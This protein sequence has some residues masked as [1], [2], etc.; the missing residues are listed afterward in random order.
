MS[1]KHIDLQVGD[2]NDW[3]FFSQAFTVG[4]GACGGGGGAGV[5]RRR[6][7]SVVGGSCAQLRS[8]LSH[9]APRLLPA[10]LLLISN[11]ALLTYILQSF[12]PDSVVHFGEQ[13]RLVCALCFCLCMHVGGVHTGERGKAQP[14]RRT[15]AP[16]RAAIPSCRQISAQ[17]YP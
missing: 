5:V 13:R 17:C 10:R 11:P 3:E 4:G 1:G 7:S 2:I 8:P 15:T 12:K 9:E 6:R 16:P 14:P